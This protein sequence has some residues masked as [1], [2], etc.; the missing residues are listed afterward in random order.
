MKRPIVVNWWVK[1]NSNTIEKTNSK[2][3]SY[4]IYQ[5]LHGELK[6]KTI[7]CNSVGVQLKKS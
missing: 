3:M 7:E 5:L 1:K 6:G 2:G 4:Q